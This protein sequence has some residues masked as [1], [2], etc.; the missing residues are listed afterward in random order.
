MFFSLRIMARIPNT[1]EKRVGQ[2]IFGFFVPKND[3]AETL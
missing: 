3:P 1:R 2:K